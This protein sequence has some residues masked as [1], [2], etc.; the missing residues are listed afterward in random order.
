MIFEAPLFIPNAKRKYDIPSVLLFSM[1]AI[2]LIIYS[3]FA[4]KKPSDEVVIIVNPFLY[5]FIGIP[6]II[7]IA[8]FFR[9]EPLNGEIKGLLIIDNSK[10]TYGDSSISLVNI[11]S[12]D[13]KIDNYYGGNIY[14]NRANGISPNL[15][16]GVKNSFM[17]NARDGKKI[18]IYFRLKD[19]GE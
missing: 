12:I 17:L 10:I 6:V 3:W 11:E 7:M 2:V 19:K 1:W 8:N 16:Q 13:F 15:S 5:L 18:L 4:I 9:Y 14:F